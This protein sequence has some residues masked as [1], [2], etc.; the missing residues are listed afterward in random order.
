MSPRKASSKLFWFAVGLCAVTLP[1]TWMAS[2]AVADDSQKQV[3]LVSAS[4]CV[5][6]PASGTQCC[7]PKI[8]ARWPCSGGEVELLGACKLS[9]SA[10]EAKG[11]LYRCGG[12]KARSR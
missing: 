3:V 7:D 1:V 4:A 10:T 8:P 9:P 11:N 6:G 12:Q 2:S 5:A